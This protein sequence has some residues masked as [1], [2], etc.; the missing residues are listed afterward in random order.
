MNMTEYFLLIIFFLPQP[1]Y[2]LIILA[3]I[4]DFL[5]AFWLISMKHRRKNEILCSEGTWADDIFWKKT[6]LHVFTLFLMEGSTL[7]GVATE[8]TFCTIYTWSMCL[9]VYM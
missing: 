2:C 7:D 1:F 4:Q 8:L 3:L 9:T 5:T 6:L